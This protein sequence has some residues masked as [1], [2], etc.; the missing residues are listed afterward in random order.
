MEVPEG[1]KAKSLVHIRLT[2]RRKGGGFVRQRQ[3][4]TAMGEAEDNERELSNVR[5]EI[6]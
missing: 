2:I 4:E 6:I 3:G 1:L 5:R